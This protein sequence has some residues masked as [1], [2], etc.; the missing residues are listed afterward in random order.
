MSGIVTPEAVPLDFE[1]AGIGSRA[2]ALLIDAVV[3]LTVQVAVS[4]GA[5][6]AFDVLPG[7]E[8]VAV[9]SLLILNFLIVFGYPTLFEVAFGGRSLGKMALGLRVVTVEGAPVGFRHAAIRSAFMLVDF[10]VTAGA[11]A[12]ITAAVTPRSQRLGDLVAGTVVL[13]QRYAG[14]SQARATRFHV[15]PWAES[16]AG[17]VSP[18][19][20]TARDYQRV[21]AF[22][23]RADELTGDARRSIAVSLAQSCLPRTPT[24]PSDMDPET[25]LRVLA[26][27]YQRGHRPPGPVPPA[28]R[29]S[30]GSS[31]MPPAPPGMPDTTR[32]PADPDR[33][34]RSGGGGFSAPG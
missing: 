11:G 29:V 12:V 5:F 7:P 34:G 4:I 19:A 3:V 18:T 22:L 15:P 8:W 26:A 28:G 31:R 21:R 2:A 16:Y 9:S 20:L 32:P 14:R 10:F 30:V 13:R 23:L 6:A 25:Y 24:P 27:V 33:S 17:T 1:H